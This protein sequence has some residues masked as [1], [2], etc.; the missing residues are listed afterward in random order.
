MMT[1][2]LTGIAPTN[3]GDD[4]VVVNDDALAHVHG[5]LAPACEE[6]REQWRELQQGELSSY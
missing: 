6:Q 2:S 1:Q 4:C 3:G 5:G